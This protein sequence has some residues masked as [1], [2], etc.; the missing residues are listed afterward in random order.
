ML[1]RI[2][3]GMNEAIP[4]AIVTIPFLVDGLFSLSAI[5]TAFVMDFSQNLK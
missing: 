3:G 1:L 5:Y 2:G 4:Y